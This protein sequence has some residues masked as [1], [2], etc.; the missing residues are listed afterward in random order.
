SLAADTL[1]ALEKVTIKGEIQNVA[2][3]KMNDF[4]GV[5]YPT[6]FDKPINVTTLVNDPGKSFPY[7]FSMQKNAIYK[8]KASVVNG[9]FE[10]SF[11]V[12]KD[13][14]YLFGNGKLSYYADNGMDD[15]GGYEL[16]VI[17]GGTADSIAT[18][19][20]GPDVSVYLNDEKF[21][22]GG[23][24]DENPVLYIKLED[25]NGINTVGNGI[26]HDIIALINDDG[27]GIKLNDYYEAELDS[28]QTGK[29]NYPLRNLPSGR[30]AVR[31]TAWDVFNNSGEG[32]TE[33]V[34][35]ESA[36]LALDHVLNYPNPFTTRTEFWFEHNRPG[37]VLD[38][39]VEI[40]SVTGKLIKT[41]IQQINTES[42]RVDGIEWDGLDNFGD[43]IGKGVYIYKLSVKA[44]SDN[45]K[46]HVFE[47]LVILR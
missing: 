1:K 7:T 38:V 26:G 5:V 43:P 27:Q 3:V 37:D 30:H 34:V 25:E 44:A 22:F 10:F 14:S 12:P 36:E 8:G 47:K 21:V 23:L 2:G 31:V 33:F 41:I 17:I 9:D 4:N 11:I 24:T 19:N 39:K 16:N 32:Y 42:Y 46:S 29:V 35:A 45:S 40:F 6:V 18:D 28:Y 15:A 20:L 13:I